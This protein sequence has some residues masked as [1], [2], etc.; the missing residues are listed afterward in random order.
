MPDDAR[1]DI[2]HNR[3]P[4][5]A[6]ILRERL[7]ERYAEIIARRDELLEAFGRAPETVDD[8]DTARRV[9]DFVKQLTSAAKTADGVR[10]K[11]KEP[12]LQGGRLVDAFFKVVTDELGKA[13]KA[14]E[15]RLTVYQRKVAEEERKRRE[16][17]ERVAR[18]E[19]ERARKE[20]EDRAAALTN[21]ADLS[22]AVEAEEAAERAAAAA[23][24]AERDAEAKAADLSRTRGDLGGVASL[25]TT[26]TFREMNRDRI[27]LEALRPHLAVDSIE[28]ALRSYIKAGGRHI[29]GAVIFEDQQTV[30]R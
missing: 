24:L 20:A 17:A 12:H 3:P 29:D 8:D 15:A 5:D 26:W 13:K 27:D 30:V 6:D 21:E 10:V 1:P 18:E 22:A 23:R 11:E 14:M 9:A 25:R 28:K 4:S 7:A 19:A 16:E 2:G